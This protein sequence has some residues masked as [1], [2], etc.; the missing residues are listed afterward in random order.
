MAAHLTVM[1]HMCK[2]WR[3]GGMACSWKSPVMER[4]MDRNRS[5]IQQVFHNV[6]W[7]HDQWIPRKSH[8]LLRRRCHWLSCYSCFVDVALSLLVAKI[9]IVWYIILEIYSLRLANLLLL[10][11]DTRLTC[12]C[13]GARHFIFYYQAFEIETGRDSEEISNTK[14]V[15]QLNNCQ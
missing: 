4:M 3:A 13:E 1:Q 5:V 2:H 14:L 10:S 6:W 12:T 11:Q 7:L 15:T 8:C 9:H